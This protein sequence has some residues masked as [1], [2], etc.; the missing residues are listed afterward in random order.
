MIHTPFMPL[1]L[2]CAVVAISLLTACASTSASTPESSAEVEDRTE[3][4]RMVSRGSFPQLSISGPN[5]AERPVARMHIRV[6]IDS[7]G[8]PDLS[9]LRVTGLGAAEN[10]NAI[11]QWIS[12]ATF[13]PAMR[14]G[15]AVSGLY[16]T[17]LE[18]RVSVRRM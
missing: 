12:G 13:R 17:R 14:N 6:M 3:P 4:P 2:A 18:V 7:E 9:T 5:P 1:R 10:R 15:E 11:E 8:R 16:E